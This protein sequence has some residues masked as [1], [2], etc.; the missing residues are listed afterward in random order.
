MAPADTRD[1]FLRAK[2]V[3][4]SNFA[5]RSTPE[6]DTRPEADGKCVLSRP[7]NEVEV[8]VVL[9]GR[10]IQDF[11]RSLADIPLLPVGIR[12]NVFLFKLLEKHSG[13][14]KQVIGVRCLVLPVA[15]VIENFVGM[16]SECVQIG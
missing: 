12:Q 16:S 11:E 5:G 8:V 10:G 9:Q 3:Q 4:F 14:I 7:V 1:L 2:V 13:S 15:A 6:V